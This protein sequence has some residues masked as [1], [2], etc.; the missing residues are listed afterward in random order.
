MI[1]IDILKHIGTGRENAV[2]RE[3]LVR[4]TGLSDRKVRMLIAAARREGEIIINAQDG[5]GYYRSNELSDLKRQ[6]RSNHNRAM[7]ILVQQKH[8]R[9]RIKEK[10]AEHGRCIYDD[11]RR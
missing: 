10:E 8:L 2:T 4:K 1:P 9:R 6:Y 5:A 3:E 11:T 7:R